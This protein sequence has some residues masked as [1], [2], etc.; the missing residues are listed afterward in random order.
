M[1]LDFKMFCNLFHR[2][3]TGAAAQWF[4]S[5]EDSK[6]R[7]WEDIMD[8]FAAQYNYNTQLD[9]T[10][11]DLQTTLQ[12]SGET[13]VDFLS[14]WR[15]KAAKMTNRPTEVEQVQIV[16]KNLQGSFKRHLIAQPLSTFQ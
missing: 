16:V 7:N 8:A 4:L 12:N 11:R 15:G 2:T 6:T 9:I 14:R 3:L 1:G 13:F 10:L 5:L